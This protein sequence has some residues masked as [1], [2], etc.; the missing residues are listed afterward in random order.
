VAGR[1][2]AALREV[3]EGGETISEGIAL[4]M[5]AQLEKSAPAK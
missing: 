1:N 2:H 4:Q 5:R 3:M